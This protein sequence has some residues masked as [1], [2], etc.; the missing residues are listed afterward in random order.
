MRLTDI[1]G[2]QLANFMENK[3]LAAGKY[4][5]TLAIPTDLVAGVYFLEISSPKGQFSIK[6]AKK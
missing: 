4:Q 3:S 2:R 1:N 6:L 5:E